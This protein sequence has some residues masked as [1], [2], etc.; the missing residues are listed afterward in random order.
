MVPLR[1]ILT[2]AL[3][4][5][6]G[7]FVLLPSSERKSGVPLHASVTGP[8]ENLGRRQFFWSTVLVCLVPATAGASEKCSD[9]ESCREL[10]EKKMQEKETQN[11]TIRLPNGVRFK[12]LRPPLGGEPVHEGSVVD[13]AFS[14][15]ANGGYLYSQGMGYEKLKNGVND[16]GLDSIRVVLGKHDVPVGIEEALI[17]MKR[18][19]RRRIELPPKVGFETSNW[20]PKPNNP[21]AEKRL[22]AYRRLLEGNANVPGYAAVSIWDVEVLKVRS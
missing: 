6:T 18:G 17:G 2:L 16:M 13:L 5:V 14:I 4:S 1:A 10:G 3:T 15:T 22:Q 8:E 19:E 21:F 11:P 9:I 7:G 12:Q 20:Q